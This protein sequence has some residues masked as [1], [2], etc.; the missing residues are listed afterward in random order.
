MQAL[1]VFFAT[2]GMDWVWAQ[3][4]ISIQKKQALWAGWYSMWI[5]GLGSVAVLSY[6]ENP[7]MLIPAVAGAFVGT[8][9]AVCRAR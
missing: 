9:F 7:L 2:V 6:T 8:V 4:T 5:L 1:M 3:Y